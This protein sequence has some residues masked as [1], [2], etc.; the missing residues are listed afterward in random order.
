VKYRL[1]APYTT[2]ITLISARNYLRSLPA[3]DSCRQLV[4]AQGNLLLH[5]VLGAKGVEFSFYGES[6]A[7]MT[8]SAEIIGILNAEPR[9]ASKY[10]GTSSLQLSDDMLL[11]YRAW[12]LG[13]VSGIVSGGKDLI[14][15]SP[16][17]VERIRAAVKR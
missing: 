2:R 4:E 10:A 3:D 12:Q 15:L 16:A 14:E 7:R 11:G 9:L 6:D 1:L 8:V 5:T 13:E 17:D